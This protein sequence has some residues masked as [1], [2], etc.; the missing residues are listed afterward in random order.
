MYDY[1]IAMQI[2]TIILRQILQLT[3]VKR[4]HSRHYV[5]FLLGFQS[6]ISLPVIRRYRH[7]KEKNVEHV[8]RLNVIPVRISFGKGSICI[9][10]KSIFTPSEIVKCARNRVDLQRI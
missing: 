1:L 7:W 6:R 5:D 10:T 2:T 3:Q 4:I 9:V 8:A